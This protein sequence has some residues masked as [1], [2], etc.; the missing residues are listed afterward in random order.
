MFVSHDSHVSGPTSLS[1]SG[2]N[3]V[4]TAGSFPSFLFF[5]LGGLRGAVVM[6]E[7][8]EEERI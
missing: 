5:G 4:S 6:D 2:R 1:L 7:E 3:E 8:E